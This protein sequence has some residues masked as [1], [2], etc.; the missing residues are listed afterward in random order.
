MSGDKLTMF[1]EPW[2]NFAGIWI[3]F[4]LR[5]NFILQQDNGT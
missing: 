3:L 1:A 4:F 5:G 2:L